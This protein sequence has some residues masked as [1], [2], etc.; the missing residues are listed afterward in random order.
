MDGPRLDSGSRGALQIL[1]MC[2]KF[3]HYTTSSL[4][5]ESHKMISSKGP[6]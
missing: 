5:S 4:I 6:G 1:L 2:T 3:M